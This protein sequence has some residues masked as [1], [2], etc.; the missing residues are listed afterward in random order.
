MVFPTKETP[1]NSDSSI[2][3][4]WHVPNLTVDFRTV[5]LPPKLLV[6]VFFHSRIFKVI[7]NFDDFAPQN[8]QN[9][10]TGPWKRYGI[11]QSYFFCSKY[12]SRFLTNIIVKLYLSYL[13]LMLRLCSVL[14]GFSPP[15]H[16]QIF[17]DPLNNCYIFQIS[18][19]SLEYILGFADIHLLLQIHVNVLDKVINWTIFCRIYKY[20]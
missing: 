16:P 15:K 3:W 7:F 2:Q 17:T 14:T 18:L 10:I 12:M 9:I 5:R 1:N 8:H 6:K 4:A 20:F 11:S 19:S 13:L